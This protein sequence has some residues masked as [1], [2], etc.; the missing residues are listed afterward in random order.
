[1]K[2]HML[3][4]FFIFI[5]VGKERGEIFIRIRD[6]YKRMSEIVNKKEVR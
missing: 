3:V 2:R 6:S 5:L 1:M 4:Y